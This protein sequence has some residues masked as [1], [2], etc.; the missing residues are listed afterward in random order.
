M[1]ARMIPRY[2]RPEMAAIFE[3]ENKFKIWLEIEILACEKMADLGVIPAS[4]PRV[5]R[6][7]GGFDVARIDEIEREVKHDVIAFL[8]SVAEHIGED[9]RYVHQ[10][11]TSSDVVDTAFAVQLTQAA[12]ILLRDL[13]KLL[14]A[15]KKR[16]EEHKHTLCIGRSHGIH[17]EPTTFGLKLAGHYAAFK[18]A[19]ARLQTAK[20]EVSVCTISGAV[21]TYASVNPQVE[22][23]VAA[24]LN[25]KPETVATQV[26]PRDRHAMFF[27]TL[28][29]IA[30]SIENLA[31]EIRHLQRTEVRE[32]EEFFAKGQKGSSAMPHKRNPILTE[33]LT[34]LA[35]L[36]RASVVPALENVALWHE[37]DISHSS[38]ERNIGPDACVTLDFALTRLTG[39]VENL[40]VYPETMMENLN[41]M[42]G[43]VFSQSVLL[44][45]TQAGVSREDAYVLVQ[46]NAMKVWAEKGHLS[47]LEA[48]LSDSDVTAKL[49]DGKLKSVCDF[50]NYTRYI[51]DVIKRA[52]A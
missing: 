2:T 49:D 51:D 24:R 30:S 4:V 33:N 14:A 16:V 6:E 25:L 31:V 39:V 9:A 28:A 45:L 50:K 21:G 43:L 18:R 38:V 35:R 22:A 46:R 13:D 10:G 19:K 8:T 40:L 27:A 7:K 15:L 17:A 3:P 37:R 44:A 11:M 5:L 29:V 26:I 41:K 52:L 36:V 20:D 1:F 47:F 48:L 23:Y 42:N 34:G 32:A 12:D